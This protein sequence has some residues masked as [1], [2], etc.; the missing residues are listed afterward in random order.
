VYD[1]GL[2]DGQFWDLTLAQFNALSRRVDA[3]AE[4][5]DFHTA[6]VCWAAMTAA[7]VK[8]NGKPVTV[9]DLMTRYEG[10]EPEPEDV[11][12]HVKNALL[13]L[14]DLP[15]HMEWTRGG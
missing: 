3:E 10:E 4:A 2:T 1:F 5:H 8:V 12:A 7:G 11:D 14:F 13:S 15:P 9:Q 6:R